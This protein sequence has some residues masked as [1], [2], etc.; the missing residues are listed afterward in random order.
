MPMV[1]PR[2]C[3]SFLD[4]DVDGDALTVKILVHP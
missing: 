1:R 2:P 3:P 4:G